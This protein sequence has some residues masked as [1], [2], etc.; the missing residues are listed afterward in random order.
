MKRGLSND[1]VVAPYATVMSLMVLP[2]QATKNLRRLNEMNFLGCY[3]MIESV[4]FTPH[5][6]RGNID[7]QPIKSFF[8][9]HQGMSFLSL[10]YCLKAQPMQR[11]FM[12]VPEFAANVLLL[13]EKIPTVPHISNPNEKETERWKNVGYNLPCANRQFQ[14]LHTYPE[15]H[16]LSNHALHVM[17][18]VNGGGYIKYEDMS[19]TRWREDATLDGY[20]VLIYFRDMQDKTD[21]W[22]ATSTPIK[23]SNDSNYSVTFSQARAEFRR[24]HKGMTTETIVT[25]SP[26][27]NV[28][29]RRVKFTNNTNK[30]KEIEFTSY[31][32]VVLNQGRADAAH[33]AFSNLFVGT[34]I[35]HQQNA[36]LF[37]RKQRDPKDKK[38]FGFHILFVHEPK[39]IIAESTF[40]TD[41]SSFL[42]RGYTMQRPK[43]LSDDLGPLS[44]TSGFPLDPI[45]AIRQCLRIKPGRTVHIDYITGVAFSKEDAISVIKKY[46][47]KKTTNHVVNFA[48]VASEKLCFRLGITEIEAQLFSKLAGCILYSNPRY[49]APPGLITKNK[50]NQSGLWKFGI[51][52]DIPLI[53]VRVCDLEQSFFMQQVLQAHA[54]CRCKGVKFDLVIWNDETTHYR[55]LL[56]QTLHHIMSHIPGSTDL[57]H[58]PGGIHPV[59]GDSLTSFETVL[60]YSVAR[61]VL[62]DN[63][64][65]LTDQ[66]NRTSKKGYVVPPFRVITQPRVIKDTMNTVPKLHERDLIL[67]NDVGGFDAK[68]K[69]YVMMLGKNHVTP[70]P[71]CNVLANDRFGSVISEKGSAYSFFTNAHEYRLTPFNNDAVLDN[72]G[73]A[74]YIRDES[75]GQYWS[76]MPQPVPIDRDD[77]Y[78]ICRHGIGY[79]TWEH[80][81]D[82]I[83]TETTTFVPQNEPVKIILI[84]VTNNSGFDRNLTVTGFVEWV[85]G[86]LRELNA[87]HII[88]DVERTDNSTAVIARNNFHIQL[89]HFVG[90][91]SVIGHKEGTITGDRNEFIG[92]N[93][94]LDRP[95]AMKQQYLSG[96]VGAAFD[97]CAAIQVPIT[98]EDGKVVEVAFM[99]GANYSRDGAKDVISRIRS[100]LIVR[101][102]LNSVKAFWHYNLN[103]IQVETPSPDLDVLANGWLLYQVLSSRIWGRS[104]F[105]Q[106]SGAFGFRDQLQDTMAVASVMPQILRQQILTNCE[107]QFEKGDVCHWWH[108]ITNSGVRTTFSDDYLWLPLAVAHYLE[109]T[110]DYKLLHE[111]IRFCKLREIEPGEESVYDK[112]EYTEETESIYEHCKRALKYGFKYGAHG[113]PLMGC[114]DWNDGMNLVGIHGKGESVWLAFFL[115]HVLENFEKNILETEIKDDEFLEECRKN[116]EYIKANIEGQAWD[117]E[118]YRRAYFD[119]GEPLGSKENS[120]CQIDSLPQSW[121][122]ISGCVDKKRAKMA[123]TNAYQRLVRHDLKLIQLF[124]PPLQHQEPS[125]GYIQGY[126]PGVRENGGQYTHASIWFAWAYS[127]LKDNKKVWDLF[128]ILNPINHAKTKEDVWKYKVE[129]YVVTADIYTLMDHEGEGGWSWFTGSGGWF[130]RLILERLIGIKKQGNSLKFDPCPKEDWKKYNINYQHGKTAYQIQVTRSEEN[131]MIVDGVKRADPTRI[132]LVDDGKTHKVEI[133]YKY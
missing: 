3:G 98:V 125:A 53:L 71:W 79:S 23:A 22:S 17:L 27:D 55:D 116:R 121:A 2:K 51:S 104:G 32:E 70:K 6:L 16:M 89:S 93:G 94:T 112:L 76:P 63:G 33:R 25:V 35:L 1:L 122:I 60:L 84:R 87:P 8:A 69:E 34:E 10:L 52:G 124:D 5:R 49:R 21:V 61:V 132:P 75:T 120:E 83:H 68:R 117:G 111:R 56:N 28:E 40:E 91:M 26:L 64:G 14:G 42:G 58:Q 11:R 13:Q 15:V 126:A 131:V 118:W 20:G 80:F 130:Y 105:Y 47:S 102:L 78:Y 96:N 77:Y 19:V 82:G 57:L 92:S 9:H 41:R 67:R 108:D 95:Q 129:P 48:W 110:E 100:N 88:T 128:D 31:G 119:S 66:I 12:A 43:A 113:L 72:S 54:Y 38:V 107:H 73:E 65:S 103:T 18:T 45:F 44:N 74:F 97:P 81:H 29:V 115:F 86:E 127:I 37:Y 39:N 90:F 62:S 85:L 101:Q 59:R 106:S 30:T 46:Q 7:A 4:D 36:I 24:K 99:I 133:Y 114:G 109:I 50:N 123:L